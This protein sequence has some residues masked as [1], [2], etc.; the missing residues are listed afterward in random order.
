MAKRILYVVGTCPSFAECS[1]VRAHRLPVAW[2]VLIGP[3]SIESEKYGRRCLK[4]EVKKPKQRPVGSDGE[5]VVADRSVQLDVRDRLK[6]DANT[7]KEYANHAKKD[8]NEAKKHR[9]EA[10][11]D[12]NK[13]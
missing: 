9:N 12:A 1:C 6:K 5:A 8:A 13:A 11:K 4:H 2:N 10:T 7:A 3:N